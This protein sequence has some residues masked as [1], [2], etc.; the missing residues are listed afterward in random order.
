MIE[1]KPTGPAQP[2]EVERQRKEPRQDDRKDQSSKKA[3]DDDMPGADGFRT[4][5]ADEDTYD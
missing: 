5:R 4:A 1:R 2:D 3:R